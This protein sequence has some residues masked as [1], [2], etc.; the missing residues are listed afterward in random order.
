MKKTYMLKYFISLFLI[1][2]SLH[3]FSQEE[4]PKDSIITSEYGLKIGIDFGKQI[5]MLTEPEYKGLSIL[6]DYR[7]YK[8]IFLVFEFGSEDKLVDNEVLNFNTK[9]T[10]YKVGANY[11]VFKNFNDLQNEIF[12]GLRFGNSKF[13]KQLNSFKIH[14]LDNYW[15]QNL[16]EQQ[17]NYDNLSASW[18]EFVVGFKAQVINNLYMGLNLKVNRLISQVEPDNFNNLFIPG[19]NKVLEDSNIGV[20]FSYTIQYQIPFFK[21]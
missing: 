3:V 15:N 11:N 13:D 10:F 14:N 18:I 19:F 4:I 1:L 17:S 9:G 2:N 6:G 5:R 7:L 21:K 20:G 8:K 16:V 12:V